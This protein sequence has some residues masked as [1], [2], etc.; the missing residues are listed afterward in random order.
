MRQDF[1]NISE[2]KPAAVDP[3]MLSGPA[4]GGFADEDP[5]G[6]FVQFLK[7]R[8]WVVAL[9]LVMGWSIGVAAN[10][11]I[12]KLYTAQA[13]IKVAEDKSSQFRL[14]PTQELTGDEDT[15]EKLDTE[16]E[17]LGSSKVIP[18]LKKNNSFA[19]LGE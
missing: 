9:A 16:I 18:R 19:P 14:E 5:F 15:A 10:H 3:S 12:P 4:I 7:K 11:F 8:L 17:I 6:R 2:P 13:D 1:S